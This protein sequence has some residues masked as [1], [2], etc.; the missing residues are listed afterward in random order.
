MSE[1]SQ[2][3]SRTPVAHLEELVDARHCRGATVLVEGESRL[4]DVQL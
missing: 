4:S 2:R 3:V 1:K